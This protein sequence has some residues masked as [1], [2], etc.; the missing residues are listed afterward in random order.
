MKAIINILKVFVRLICVVL[1]F[2]TLPLSIIQLILVGC[3]W[4][5]TGHC[6][7]G[8]PWAFTI[9]E[10]FNDFFTD[11]LDDKCNYII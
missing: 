11:V 4:V 3:K 2:V 1:F 8:D 10:K 5:F 9:V 6:N 7:L